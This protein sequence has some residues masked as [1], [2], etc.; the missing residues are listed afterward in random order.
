MRPQKGAFALKEIFSGEQTYSCRLAIQTR[1]R[2]FC[3]FSLFNFN[4]SRLFHWSGW[5]KLNKTE[6]FL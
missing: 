6:W 3:V 2:G 1:F 4:F 5:K